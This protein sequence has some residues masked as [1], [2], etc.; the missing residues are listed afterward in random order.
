[1]WT[2]KRLLKHRDGHC[3]GFVLRESFFYSACNIHDRCYG[4]ICESSPERKRLCDEG[5]FHDMTRACVDAFHAGRISF[6]EREVCEKQALIYYNAVSSMG[7]G[8]FE[9]AQDEACVWEEC[10]LF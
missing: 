4:Q 9:E 1:M 8:A 10:K 2:G 7:G 5:L 3:S 6:D